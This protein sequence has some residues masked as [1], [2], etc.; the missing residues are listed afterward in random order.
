V[1]DTVTIRRYRLEDSSALYEAALES[2]GEVFPW[3][4]W[5]HPAL[6]RQECDEWTSSRQTL[7]DQGIEYNF[8]IFGADARFLGGC[9]LN[10]IQHAHR[11]ANLG[12]W[13]RTSKTGRGVA[14][15]AVRQLA[16]F[17]FT[18]TDL[19]RLEIVCA[20]GNAASQRV[21]EN[22]GAVREGVLGDRLT[23]HAISHDAVMFALLKSKWS[24]SA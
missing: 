9:A 6:T 4:P 12:Y 17:A 10:S 22:A 1:R 5:C 2:V 8:A 21:A 14:A 19:V 15:A 3:L 24:E 7:F 16:S 13:V 20:V 23:L 18:R 11:L